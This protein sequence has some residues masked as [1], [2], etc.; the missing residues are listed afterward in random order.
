MHSLSGTTRG[1]N[2]GPLDPKSDTLTTTLPRP[3][4]AVWQHKLAN[5]WTRL[6][7]YVPQS[8]PLATSIY[9]YSFIHQNTGRE[10]K[11]KQYKQ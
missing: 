8:L 4:G 6:E 11:Y 10:H 1:S 3:F 2:P 9:I 5:D 7:N